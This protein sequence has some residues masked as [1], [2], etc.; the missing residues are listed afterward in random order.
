MIKIDSLKLLVPY[1]AVRK[2]DEKKFLTKIV[3][4][5][6]GKG[7]KK[8][9][10]NKGLLG[11]KY[12]EIDYTRNKIIIEISSKI[13]KESYP[14]L[15]NVNTIERAIYN[16]EQYGFVK[17]NFNKFIDSARPLYF[18]LSANLKMKHQPEIYLRDL[19]IFPIQP[20]YNRSFGR[21]RLI[22][23]SQS[24]RLLIYDKSK[25]L[26]SNKKTNQK[27]KKFIDAEIFKNV[28]RVE[29]SYKTFRKMREGFSI[30]NNDTVYLKDILNSKINLLMKD[31]NRIFKLGKN[32]M[33]ERKSKLIKSH[34]SISEI[35][36]L[37]GRRLIANKFN[38]DMNEIKLFLK[39]KVKGNIHSRYM[40]NYKK[41]VHSSLYSKLNQYKNINEVREKLER[42]PFPAQ[43]YFDFMM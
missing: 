29:S 18:D 2:I 26:S 34:L 11:L 14:D 43:R 19:K 15:I 37:L 5:E 27:L 40:P 41:T 24:L 1:D 7:N 31:F 38:Y 23:Y 17:F 36:K 32:E 12:I 39:S 9:F 6:N 10:F 4:D 33:F 3:I 25:E 16:L 13:L 21:G 42:F 22:I 28:L 35:E 8:L 30:A 20:I